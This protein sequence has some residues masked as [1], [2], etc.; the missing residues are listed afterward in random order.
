MAIN[1]VK[2]IPRDN[3]EKGRTN[4]INLLAR[5]YAPKL[6]GPNPKAKNLV[7]NTIAIIITNEVSPVNKTSL[8]NG[9]SFTCK[10]FCTI[11][12][13]YLLKNNTLYD[14]LSI[15]SPV[16]TSHPLSVFL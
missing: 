6:S 9:L 14:Q 7:V 1:L 2:E 10:C 5:E 12:Y 16:I 8:K 13:L 15:I 3:V 4:A 11:I